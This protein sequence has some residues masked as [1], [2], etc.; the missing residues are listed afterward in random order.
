VTHQDLETLYEAMALGIDAVG[1]EHSQL[2]LAKIALALAEA[3]DDVPAAL[4]VIENCK[5]DLSR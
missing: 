2:Y 1:P 5:A 3:L 4:D